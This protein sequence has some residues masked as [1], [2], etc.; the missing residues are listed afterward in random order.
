MCRLK[1]L[2]N[3]EPLEEV[4][5]L[6]NDMKSEDGVKLLQNSL[7]PRY[8]SRFVIFTGWKFDVGGTIYDHCNPQR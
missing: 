8:D 1:N 3:K 7:S 2:I 5:K 4:L 6:I